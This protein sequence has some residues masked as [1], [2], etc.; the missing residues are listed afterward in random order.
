MLNKI[1]S[2]LVCSA[3]IFSLTSCANLDTKQKQG[4]AVGAG[5]GAGVGAILG[6]AIGN[7][8]ESTLIGAGIGAAL[9]GLAGNQVGLYMDR[10]EQ[11]LRNAIARSEAASIQR[12]QDVLTATFKGE[13][14]FDHDSAQLLPGGYSEVS[15]VASVLRKYNQTQIEVAGHTDITGPADY[16]QQLSVRRA[17][18]VKNALI[19]QGVA[20]ERIVAVGYGETQPISSNH[21]TNR[22]V[23]IVIVPITRG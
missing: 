7:D 10:Q 3:V 9:G 17:E 13:A 23:E 15:R 18:S 2:I 1:F 14:F 22:R 12:D 20:P 8:T 21:A 19:Q 5:V 16:N 4:T 11:E 6:Q